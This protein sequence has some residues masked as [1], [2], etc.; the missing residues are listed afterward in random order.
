MKEKIKP[1]IFYIVFFLFILALSTTAS[2]YDFDLWA[3]LIVGK[4]FVQ[5][6]QVL[7]QDFLS[8]T[9][10]H[11]WFDHE[12]GSGV[13]FYLTQHYFSS[14]GLLIL[15]SLLIFA[16][17]F[18]I[19][20]IVKLRGIKTTS[21]Y[22]F[23][24]YYFTFSAMSQ[25][26]NNPIRCQLFSFL[27]FTIFLYILELTRKCENRPLFAIPFIMIIWNNLHGG[28]ISGIGLIAIY[29]LGEF[30]D[31]KPIKK[32]FFALISSILVLPI[33]PWGISY[34]SFLLKANLMQRTYITEW[35]GTFC[36]LNLISYLKFKFFALVLLLTELGLVTKR[37]K[38]K[39][40]NLDKTAFLVL[41]T[42]LIL[43]IQHA[44][45]IPFFVISAACFLYDDF[46]T[47]FNSITRN[48]FNKIA[49]YKDTFI[50]GLILAFCI[51]NIN[52]HLTTVIINPERYP[53]LSVEFIKEN[54]LKGN[55]FTNFGLGSYA[56]YK[57]YPNNKIFIDGRYEEVY[58]D[59][60]MK[61]LS[62]FYY[63]RANRNEALTKFPADVLL[64][65]K[66]YKIYN[67]IKS[68]KEWK[69]VYDKDQY[70]GVFVKTN[71]AKEN[72][73]QP[74]TNINYYRRTLFDTDINFK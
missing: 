25:I 34:I 56:A 57:L 4:A 13:L 53:I 16:I 7:K 64:I 36:K 3:R 29:I 62:D 58:Y 69:L 28:C 27:F 40:F 54:N 42:T 37:I 32:Y 38:S 73:K 19:T 14:A 68:Q 1:I 20:K 60:L 11:I 67:V 50:Y 31:K 66:Y 21:A 8:Y 17:F 65:E 59:D 48:L 18:F 44:K 6:G 12:W 2:N 41:L 24:F 15:Q 47:A 35:W 46:Y 10:T 70:F 39:E 63:V 55:L 49:N 61:L 74:T 5:T 26:L 9:P 52:K 72:Y 71:K 43:A 30:L 22:N 51:F 23:L 33:N 45:L